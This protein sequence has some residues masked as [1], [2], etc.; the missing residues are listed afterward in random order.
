MGINERQ[1]SFQNLVQFAGR[2]C[3][4]FFVLLLLARVADAQTTCAAQHS[5][6]GAFICYP[7]P[8]E[9]PADSSV[10]HIFHLSAQGN[11]PD[12]QAIAGYLVLID[13]RPVYETQLAVPVLKLSIETNLKSPFNTGSHTLRLVVR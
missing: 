4:G 2:V 12:G 10:P 1:L 3:C 13:N 7:N 9:N 11:A 6:R 8:S 5:A